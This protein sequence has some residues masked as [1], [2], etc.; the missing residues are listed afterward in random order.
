MNEAN[1]KAVEETSVEEEA[2]KEEAAKEEAAKEEAAKEK[3][4]DGKADE[5]VNTAVF[6]AEQNMRL[7]ELAHDCVYINSDEKEQTIKLLEEK[8]KEHSDFNVID[9]FIWNLRRFPLEFDQ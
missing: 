2:A 3:P 7:L 4:D 6:T 5:A 1:E 8:T 9:I